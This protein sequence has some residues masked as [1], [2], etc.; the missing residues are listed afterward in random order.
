MP[1]QSYSR[2]MIRFVSLLL[3]VLMMRAIALAQNKEVLITVSGPWAYMQDPDTNHKG[4][5]IIMAPD[6]TGAGHRKVQMRPAPGGAAAPSATS[7]LDD[8]QYQ[9]DIANPAANCDRTDVQGAEVKALLF[10][11]R[12][13]F[14]QSDQDLKNAVQTALQANGKRIA[15]SLPAP[16]YYSTLQA[17]FSIISENPIPVPATGDQDAAGDPYTTE[18]VLH[19]FVTAIAPATLT[20]MPDPPG[21][22]STLPVE[23]L[24]NKIEI[25]LRSS[26]FLSN[27]SRCDSM[28]AGSFRAEVTPFIP[29]QSVVH[30]WFPE[31][32]GGFQAG[33]KGHYH[34]ECIDASMM[35]ARI[36]K[37]QKQSAANALAGINALQAYVK[38]QRPGQE[39]AIEKHL[40]TIQTSLDSLRPAGLKGGM[41]LKSDYPKAK[42]EVEAARKALASKKRLSTK[43]FEFSNARKFVERASPGSA[44]CQGGQ[45]SVD[46]TGG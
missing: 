44:D 8:G 24:L 32:V 46:G 18:M 5:I 36:A 6:L 13:H 12:T 33:N 10:P 25:D 21:T 1:A 26:N 28:S 7:S 35:T 3:V 34:A 11:L 19:Y 16:C 22:Q 23:F 20:S 29:S 2:S 4:R 31:L 9:L 30:S 27:S 43:D 15:I 14:P 42:Q 41:A 40:T 37:I 39:K 17:S 45:G 38:H